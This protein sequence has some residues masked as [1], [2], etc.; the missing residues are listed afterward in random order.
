MI[1]KKTFFIAWAMFCAVSLSA[2][3]VMRL[4]LAEC[5]D[6]AESHNNTL[7]TAA[8]NRLSSEVSYKESKLKYAPTVSAS[9]SQGYGYSNRTGTSSWNGNYGISAGMTL[10][11][12]FNTHNNVKINELSLKQ[13]EL[14]EVQSRNSMNIRIMQSYLT[15]LMNTER[16]IYQQE[17][18]KT[19]QEQVKEGELQ[20]KV[21]QMLESDYNLLKANLTGATYDVENTK[22]TI[23]NELLTLKNLLGL[24]A[25]TKLEIKKPDLD[26]DNESLTMPTLETAVEKALAYLP[27]LKSSDADV[28]MAKY[29]VKVAKSNYSPTLSLSAGV[30]TGY[31]N[32]DESWGTQV[33][34]NLGENVGLNLS[35]PIYNRSGTRSKVKQSKIRLQQAEIENEQL[36][37]DI[38]SEIE[39]KY[40]SVAQSF[41]TYKSSEA[42]EKAYKDSY[43]VYNEKFKVGAITTVDLLQQ[44]N[45]YLNALNQYLQ[46]KYSYLLNRKILDVYMGVPLK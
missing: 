24:P 12:G 23:D 28:D 33:S 40:L 4:S 29:D 37:L 35:V 2:Q 11:D 27:E 18:V 32:F 20:Y 38:T 19:S 41:N 46:N 31:T 8:L 13:S 34:N 17:V 45:N 36:K 6:Y 22:I 5:I 25:S 1:G 3:G 21:G 9:A 15:I 14:Q 43:A 44:Q 26:A 16:L 7:R 30:S 42:L 39:Q 10:F